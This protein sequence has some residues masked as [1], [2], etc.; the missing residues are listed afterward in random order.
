MARDIQL[1]GP[2]SVLGMPLAFIEGSA[3]FSGINGIEPPHDE[4]LYISRVFHQAMVEVNEE[5]TDAAAATAIVH[6]RLSKSFGPAPVPVFRAD[7]PFLFAIRDK[8][9]GAIL[10]LGRVDIPA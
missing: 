7:H 10:F 4:S 2:L 8:N 9:S 5:G 6:T 3:N 1:N